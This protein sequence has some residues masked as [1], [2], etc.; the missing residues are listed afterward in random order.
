MNTGIGDAVNLAWKLAAVLHGAAAP[1]LLDT[2]ETERMR[3]AR[4]LVATTDRVFSLLNGTSALARAFRTV[5][6][7]GLMPQL[8]RTRTGKRAAFRVLSQIS[9]N[10]RASAISEGRAGKV[11]GGDRL[12]WVD[13]N[14]T[15]LDTMAWQAHVY[16]VAS[17]R[18][19][20][21]CGARGL[22]LHE[23][24]WSDE[25][26]NAGFRRDALYVVRPDGHVGLAASDP[27][28]ALMR[29]LPTY[30]FHARLNGD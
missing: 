28:D 6:A 20:A 24:P 2:Y 5:I 8:L 7:P 18:V 26:R 14:F 9:I 10:Y 11:H 25:A 19:R 13:G 15:V 29:Y 30:N 12:P 22:P 17:T 23:F 21:A 1:L 27:G 16:G 3:F 4:L